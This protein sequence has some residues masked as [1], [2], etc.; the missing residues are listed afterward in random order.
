MFWKYVANLQENI[1]AKEATLLKSHFGMA[2]LL[3]ICCIFSKN[4]FLRT[5]LDGCFWM[6]DDTKR[7]EHYLSVLY[8][9]FNYRQHH[10][11]INIKEKKS[12]LQNIACKTSRSNLE[13]EF[14][15][16]LTK[17][18]IEFPRVL[19][20]WLWSFRGATHSYRIKLFPEFW[21]EI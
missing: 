15:G 1:H 19:F 13:K 5:P 4:L 12:V 20:S 2:V 18:L 16:V 14:L 9:L 3:Q 8:N 21:R 6:Y 11:F 10:Q 7:N 17:S